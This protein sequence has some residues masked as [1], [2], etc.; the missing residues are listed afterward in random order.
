MGLSRLSGKCRKCKHVDTCDHKR[1]EALAYYEEA[2]VN[3]G[4]LASSPV[5]QP[6]DYRDIKISADVTATIDLEE[7]K[8]KINKSLYGNLMQLGSYER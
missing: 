7:M 4:Q 2:H 5:M 8:R 6:R 3:T 1:M